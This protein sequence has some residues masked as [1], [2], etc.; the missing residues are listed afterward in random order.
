MFGNPS[1]WIGI[2]A[3][4][5]VTLYLKGYF[6]LPSLPSRLPV[7]P[8]QASAT[9]LTSHQLGV[10]FAQAKRKEAEDELA[11]LFAQQAGD[12]LKQSF[13]APFTQPASAGPDQ[14]APAD[15]PAA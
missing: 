3:V 1:V 5:A 6:R 12:T 7:A 9:G 13:S 11:A 8:S 10:L 15:Q 2:A 14:A 4:V